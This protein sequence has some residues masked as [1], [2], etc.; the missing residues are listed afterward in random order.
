[1]AG[2]SKSRVSQAGAGSDAGGVSVADCELK[3]ETFT[4]KSTE[5]A[6]EKSLAREAESSFQRMPGDC[7]RN[8]KLKGILRL[9][10]VSA[11]NAET[12]LAQDDNH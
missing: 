7:L 6:E 3:A 4:T 1:M 2:G 8:E 10:L 11:L 12:I 9:R 5:S